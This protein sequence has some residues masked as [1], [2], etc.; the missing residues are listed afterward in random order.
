[1]GLP[2][3]MVTVGCRE[4]EARLVDGDARDHAGGD[5]GGGAGTGVGVTPGG[6]IAT[7]GAEV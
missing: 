2:P 5:L 7:V 4:A 6:V 1:M 3:A